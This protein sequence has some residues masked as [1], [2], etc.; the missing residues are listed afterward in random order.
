MTRKK[1]DTIKE[2]ERGVEGKSKEIQEKG[3]EGD[4]KE[5]IKVSVEIGK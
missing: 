2:E 5:R 4:R 3:I 1:R